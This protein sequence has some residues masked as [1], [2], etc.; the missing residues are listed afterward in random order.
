MGR[1]EEWL[2]GR[3][4][5]GLLR[6]RLLP[7]RLPVGCVPRPGLVDRVLTALKGRVVT[8]VAGAR[9][10]GRCRAGGVER[11]EEALAF[12]EAESA[13]VLR[14][15]RLALSPK[16]VEDLHRATEGWAAGLILAA[17]SGSTLQHLRGERKHSRKCPL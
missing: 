4:V 1:S 5:A 15:A 2:G 16:S 3:P 17:Q 6:T 13:E 9:A 10:L 8:V 7:P 14:A 11:G 12:T